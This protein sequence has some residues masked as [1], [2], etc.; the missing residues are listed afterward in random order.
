MTLVGV[1]TVR[2]LLMSAC[3]V[4]TSACDAATPGTPGL[5]MGAPVDS[6]VALDTGAPRDSGMPNDSGTPASDLGSSD[7]G[8][9]HERD[10][11]IF[12]ADFEGSNPFE[13]FSNSQHCCEHSVTQSNTYARHG[14]S[15][16]RAEVRSDD[17]SVSS[18]YRAEILPMGVT[19]DGEM[20]YGYSILFEAPIADG[21]WNGVNG[22]F[23]QWH[24]DNSYG[25]SS[26]SLWSYGGVWEIHTNPDGERD[27]IQH[28]DT[29][30]GDDIR[31]ESLRW[32]DIVWHVNWDTGHVELF[33]DGVKYFDVTDH[34]YA[35]QYFKLGMNRWLVDE[36]WVIY[37]DDLRIGDSGATYEDVAP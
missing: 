34:E 37:Y 32:F 10:H 27:T 26:L 9:P 33:V 8:T 6:G 2:G 23:T 22:V 30:I 19:D 1:R 25:S 20:W 16:Y 3:L 28:T 7:G 17:P 12:E 5:D 15:S 35:G 29:L 24:P 21:Y 18:G 13:N 11:L 36:T 31:I 4:A 14:E